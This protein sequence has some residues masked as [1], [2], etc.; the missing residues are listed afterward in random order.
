MKPTN[1]VKHSVIEEEEETLGCDYLFPD[2]LLTDFLHIYTATL[3][4]FND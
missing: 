4:F 3:H 1:T 2:F